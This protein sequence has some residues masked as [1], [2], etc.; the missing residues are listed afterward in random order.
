MRCFFISGFDTDVDGNTLYIRVSPVK[1]EKYFSKI[2]FSR[3]VNCKKM[4]FDKC[5][6]IVSSW[7]VVDQRGRTCTHTVCIMFEY[8]YFHTVEPR[9]IIVVTS[10]KK[11]FSRSR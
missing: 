10:E 1:Y 7:N 8:I 5:V 11:Y 9:E 3:K 6:R 4:I 2:S